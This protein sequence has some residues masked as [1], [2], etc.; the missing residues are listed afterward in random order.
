VSAV[1]IR[2]T[3]SMVGKGVGVGRGVLV[4]VGPGV[5]VG[6]AVGRGRGTGSGNDWQAESAK[7][8]HNQANFLVG[9][10]KTL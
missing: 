9:F 7:R 10:M 5:F 6:S 2:T 1:S 8:I 4:G 3:G